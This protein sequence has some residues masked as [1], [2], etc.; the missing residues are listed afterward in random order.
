MKRENLIGGIIPTN[1]GNTDEFQKL[2]NENFNTTDLI[3]LASYYDEQYS[4]NHDEQHSFVQ[5]II[6]ATDYAIMN[7]AYTNKYNCTLTGKPAT[8]VW[9]RSAFSK[10]NIHFLMWQR[11]LVPYIH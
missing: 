7:H 5:L 11:R 9:L 1:I 10:Y 6:S 4:G 8:I 2:G 3:Y